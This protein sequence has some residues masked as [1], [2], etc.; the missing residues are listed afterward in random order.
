M[1]ILDWM[2][3]YIVAGVRF[4]LHARGL[5]D[6]PRGKVLLSLPQGDQAREVVGAPTG[7][8]R[9]LT[10]ALAYGGRTESSVT[11]EEPETLDAELLQEEE[12]EEKTEAESTRP[13]LTM[14]T[15]G[16]RLDGGATGYA[17]VSKKGQAWAGAKVHMG[18]NQEAY[19]ADCAALAHALELAARRNTTLQWITIFSDGQAAIRRMASEEPDPGSSTQ[20]RRE[21]TSPRC[22]G[23]GQVSPWRSGGARPTKVSPATRRPTCG[24]RVRQRSQGPTDLSHDLSPT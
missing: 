24:T 14:F 15:D 12:A 16:S 10:N 18:N 7:I 1:K 20:S 13:G 11:L 22:D 3:W 8:G 21:S 23:L 19:D 4:S 2:D 5:R 17:V 9:R 6:S